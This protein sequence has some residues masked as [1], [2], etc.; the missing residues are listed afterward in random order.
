MSSEVFVVAYEGAQDDPGVLGYAMQRAAVEGATLLLV[1][2][3]E[4]SPYSFLTPEE[5]EERHGRRA[6]EIERA[7]SDVTGPALDKVKAAGIE[8]ECVIRYGNVVEL[9]VE[10]AGK[11]GAGMIFVGRSGSQSVAARVFGSVPMGLAQI[12]PVPLV[13]VP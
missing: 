12:S 7:R 10:E 3:L 4:W 6:K 1:H 9:V 8:A 5:L 11:A 2:V 13:I